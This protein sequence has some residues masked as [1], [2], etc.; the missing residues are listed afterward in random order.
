MQGN[1]DL[2]SRYHPHSTASTARSNAGTSHRNVCE[3]VGL[4]LRTRACITPL[5]ATSWRDGP[6]RARGSGVG[7]G[8]EPVGPL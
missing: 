6:M 8:A 2:H 4:E 1:T 3:H 5:S 7:G